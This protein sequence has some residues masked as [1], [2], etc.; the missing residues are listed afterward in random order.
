M[1]ELANLINILLESLLDLGLQKTP[2][3]HPGETVRDLGD[4]CPCLLCVVD[5]EVEFGEVDEERVY[6]PLCDHHTILHHVR[7]CIVKSPNQI[8]LEEDIQQQNLAPIGE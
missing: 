2:A 4:G 1:C 5:E 6:V 7:V 8:G 3:K